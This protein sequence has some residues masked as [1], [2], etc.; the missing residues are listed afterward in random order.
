VTAADVLV[1]LA[2]AAVA[3]VLRVAV[4]AGREPGGVDSWYCLAYA[5]ALRR[6]PRLRV[7]LPQYLLQDRVQSYPPLFPWVLAALPRGW[8]A[9]SFW[10]VSPAFDCAHLLLLYAVTHRITAS[11]TVAALSAAVYAVVPHLV[12]ETRSLSARSFSSLVLTLAVLAMLKHVALDGGWVWLLAALLAGGGVFL[13]SAT[14]AG[15]YGV[16]AA[17]LSLKGG[18]PRY[19]LVVAGAFVTALVGSRGLLL[20]VLANYAHAIR[21]WR[22]HRARYG[23]HTVH[24]SPLYGR[25]DA[26]APPADTGPLGGARA[27]RLLRLLGENPFI[28]ALPLAPPGL[29]PIGTA[30]STWAYALTALALAV[31]LVPALRGLGPG[32]N[33]VK[34]AIFPTAYTLGVAVG[35]PSHLG[36]PVGVATLAGI[37]SSLAGVA[38]FIVYTRRRRTEHTAAVPPGLRAAVER[39]RGL[40]GDG[41]FC[42]PLSYADYTTYHSG[43][44]V[45]WG[46]HCGD[47]RALASVW[48]VLSE[49]LPDL[50]ARYGVSYLLLDSRFASREELRLDDL[51]LVGAFDGVELWELANH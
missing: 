29:P 13:A 21:F 19:L 31:T 47:L 48:P 45:L 39:L 43:K 30:M 27:G 42:L 6:R 28:L 36:S 38:A 32:R 50:F 20:D 11:T 15:A 41:V 3:F 40:P 44:S 7:E 37:A 18:D 22:R 35:H 2:L 12:S 25:P 9:R 24:H 8:L 1:A 33:Y 46:G 34:T 23:A 49:P 4:H 51:R 5:D 26:G 14:A 16:A 10:L 17:A